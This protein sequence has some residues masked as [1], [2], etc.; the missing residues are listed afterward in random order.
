[1]GLRS[2]EDWSDSQ[3]LLAIAANSEPDRCSL[4][5]RLGSTS[6]VTAQESESDVQ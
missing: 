1:M 5:E 3:L 6:N 4:A 2:R